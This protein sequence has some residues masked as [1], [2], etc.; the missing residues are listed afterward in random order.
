MLFRRRG[1]GGEDPAGDENDPT[2]PGESTLSRFDAAASERTLAACAGIL[3]WCDTAILESTRASAPFL[4]MGQKAAIQS[5]ATNFERRQTLS[6]GNLLPE[7]PAPA[8]SA[9]P[10]MPPDF[11][12]REELEAMIEHRIEIAIQEALK[13]LGVSPDATIDRQVERQVEVQLATQEQRLLEYVKHQLTDSLRM[14]EGTLSN[15]ISDLAEGRTPEHDREAAR[16]EVEAQVEEARETLLRHIEEVRTVDVGFNIDNYAA[17]LAGMA[18]FG[19]SAPTEEIEVGGD[20]DEEIAVVEAEDEDAKEGEEI[21]VVEAE[22][23]P[24]ADS[25]DS[26]ADTAA[27][28][29]ADPAPS[30]EEP[31]QEEAEASPSDEASADTV[32]EVATEVVA[33][34]NDGEDVEIRPDL[35][36]A[37]DI[38]EIDLDGDLADSAVLTDQG[39][40][41]EL[42]DD[43]TVDATTAA[44]DEQKAIE[45]YL[46]E[47]ARLAEAGDHKG[48]VTAYD[49]CININDQNA[50][51]YYKRGLVLDEMGE[52]RKAFLDLMRARDLDGDLPD[53]RKLI[54]ECRKKVNKGGKA[55]KKETKKKK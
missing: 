52:H 11:P 24:P 39:I 38:A 50:M 37:N 40:T 10:Q 17:E 3:S 32:D 34:D 44:E 6:L 7:A 25:P 22:E 2:S 14:L 5:T 21:A 13:N 27:E 55:A 8:T 47:G 19:G 28:P 12:T 18:E 23:E 43:Q 42:D 29:E 41:L 15:Q 45:H 31:A 1:E 9:Q 16:A 20:E 36:E 33:E 49:S 53:I 30:T 26:N 48:A 46:S 51:A 54:S 4:S 35:A